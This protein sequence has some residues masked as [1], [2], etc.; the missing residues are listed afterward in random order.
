MGYRNNKLTAAAAGLAAVLVLSY[1][2]AVAA[3]A[4][5]DAPAKNQEVS[6]EI[7]KFCSATGFKETCLKSLAGAKS[8]KPKDLIKTAFDSTV[9]EI[10]AA[11]KNTGTYKKLASDKW[12]RGALDVC[13]RVLD[14]SIDDVRK[15]FTNV[16]SFEVGKVNHALD[17]V[18]IWL[19]SAITNKETCIDAFAK[20][21]STYTKLS[22]FLEL[23]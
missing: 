17:D 9:A 18:K 15:S 14:V 19:S 11:I 8:T 23:L 7:D 6:G 16:D 3:A 21:R 2:G 1:I 10:Q 13:E 4:V 5:A 22:I 12:T 20:T